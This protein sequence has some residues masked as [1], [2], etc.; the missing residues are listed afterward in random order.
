MLIFADTSPGRWLRLREVV[1]TV[2]DSRGAH[3]PRASPHGNQP[4][5]HEAR[6]RWLTW[7][8][9]LRWLTHDALRPTPWPRLFFND[10]SP[11]RRRHLRYL[12]V[13]VVDSRGARP[14]HAS[15]RREPA[16][17]LRSTRALAD[18]AWLPLR[19]THNALHPTLLAEDLLHR[20]CARAAGAASDH[21]GRCVDYSAA[22]PAR[23]TPRGERAD[24]TW[25]TAALEELVR[26][27]SRP[28]RDALHPTPLVEALFRRHRARS[29]AATS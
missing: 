3:P 22:Q 6:V 12:M 16:N 5:A 13:T 28:K 11:G 27:S 1:A 29:A 24:R 8:G 4:T 2:F 19:P 21:H 7:R 26:L 23:A 9:C 15:P 20:H 14:A 25:C 18:L 10:T 17:R